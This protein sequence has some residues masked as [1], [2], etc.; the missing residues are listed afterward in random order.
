MLSED[1]IAAVA[2]APGRSA[3]ALVRVSGPDAWEIAGRVLGPWPPVPRRATL[4]TARD[5]ETGER[6]DRVIATTFEAPHS[7]TGQRVVEIATHGGALIPATILAALVAAGARPALGGEFTRR[8]LLGGKLDVAQAEAIGD[9][10]D[11]RSGAARRAALAQLDGGLSRRV[12]ALRAALIETEALIAYEIDFPEEDDGPI[13]PARIAASAAAAAGA[14]AQLLATAPVGALVREGALVVIA[15]P[16][17]VGKSS[18]FNAI[19]GRAQAIVTEIPGTTRDAIEALVEPP[20]AAFPLRL[21][22]TAGLRETSD[23]V[24]RLG[25][26]VS[27]RYLAGA[28][29]ILACGET[30]AAIDATV[31]RVRAHSEAPVV[32]VLTKAD[33]RGAILHGAIATSAETGAGIRELLAAVYAAVGAATPDPDTPIVTRARHRESLTRASAELRLFVDTWEAHTVPAVI[34]A[35]HLRSAVD[36]LEDIIGVVDTDNVLDRLFSEFCV[37]K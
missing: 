24:E 15:G 29:A 35:V 33:L 10:I 37:G 5:P 21:V 18:L 34:A 11:A 19:L 26:E 20:G 3:L 22:D 13:P 14:L 32:S 1:T 36:A 6:L 12:A 4:L 23:V 17:N 7:F 2:T 27:E 31:A 8:A 9:L 16:P 28:H 25:I 30:A